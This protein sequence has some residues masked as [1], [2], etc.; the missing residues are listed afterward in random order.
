MRQAKDRGPARAA[1]FAAAAL[2]CAAGCGRQNPRESAA[3]WRVVRQDL[4]IEVQKG[5]S[6]RAARNSEVR[7]EVLGESRII[8]LVPE[9]SQVKEGEVLVRL[10]SSDLEEKLTQ[11]EIQY[12]NALAAKIQADEEYLIQESQNES[13]IDQALLAF[14]LAVMD[15]QKYTGLSVPVPDPAPGTMASDSA[16]S[17]SAPE[18][19]PDTVLPPEL[20]AEQILRLPL[21]SYTNGDAAQLWRE[22]DSSVKLAAAELEKSRGDK[23]G[24]EALF[25]KKFV[26]ETDVVRDRISFQRAEI[27][28]RK[29]EEQLRLL[30]EF[31]HPRNVKQY[32]STAR[33][34]GK[35]MER[36]KRKARAALSGAEASRKSKTS[37][38]DHQKKLL[39][40]FQD[41]V[42]KCTIKA[43][44]PGMVVYARTEGMRQMSGQYIEEG[45]TVRERQRLIDLPDLTQFVA[46]VM[47][48]ESKIGQVEI[49][50]SADITI[51]ARRGVTLTGKVTRVAVLPDAVDRWRN[52][53][54][55]QYAV[56]VTL[57]DA[58]GLD[59]KPGLTANV[60]IKVDLRPNALVVP[61]QAVTPIGSARVV[62]IVRGQNVVRQEVK[63]GKYND[64]YVEILEGLAEGDEV[65]LQSVPQE[66]GAGAKG[67]ENSRADGGN[68]N[69]NGAA[70]PGPAAVPGPGVAPGPGAAQDGAAAGAPEGVRRMPPAFENL[71]EEQK[72]ELRKLRKSRGGARG[73][74]GAGAPQG[75]QGAEGGQ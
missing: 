22:A 60:V 30:K 51:S 32:A 61:L 9:G 26:A 41:Q 67:K 47:I 63:I 72:A 29:A 1:A 52:P 28:L 58:Q 20:D 71:T 62:Q 27:N 38:Y 19:I 45:A 64:V 68:K 18:V 46:D 36:V 54:L 24:S 11:Q 55:K 12:Q 70:A 8:S 50:Q 3:T 5:G 2:L 57:D 40:R 25:A 6:L 74:D 31:T 14:D 33:E 65:L 16:V 49:G 73:G 69:G 34:K 23:D 7:C 59:L 39:E 17:S 56:Q 48:H 15:L 35:Q 75:G 66:E 21:V 10:D 44:T 4:P 13:D 42:E 53:D 43:P 37:T